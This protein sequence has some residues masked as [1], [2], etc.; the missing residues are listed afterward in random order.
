MNKMLGSKSFDLCNKY[1]YSDLIWVRHS[2]S[3]GF[4]NINLFNPHNPLRWVL[5][6]SLYADGET[7]VGK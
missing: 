1:L 7:K 2:T 3:K 4:S 6:L 5:L